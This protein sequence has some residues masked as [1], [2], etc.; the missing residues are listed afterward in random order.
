MN[1]DL[2]SLSSAAYQSF[3]QDIWNHRAAHDHLLSHLYYTLNGADLCQT[4]RR[5]GGPQIKEN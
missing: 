3:I 5:A 2:S 4:Q 1:H